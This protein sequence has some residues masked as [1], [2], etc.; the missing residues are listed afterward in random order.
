M[1]LIPNTEKKMKKIVDEES[2]KG[3]YV[4]LLSGQLKLILLFIG[5]LMF[6]KFCLKDLI[7]KMF[8]TQISMKQY[9]IIYFSTVTN[10]SKLILNPIDI[11]RQKNCHLK[12]SMGKD[13]FIERKLEGKMSHHLSW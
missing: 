5:I 11:V 8:K 9:L 12:Q 4:V 3:E 13:L 6:G 1:G 10:I 2:R 7:L